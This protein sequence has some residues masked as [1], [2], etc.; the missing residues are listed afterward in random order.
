MT[1][2][3]EADEGRSPAGRA[4]R[5]RRAPREPR[6]RSA[7]AGGEA[8]ATPNAT[9]AFIADD[10]QDRH[11]TPDIAPQSNDENEGK[12][13]ASPGRM[14]VDAARDAPIRAIGRLWGAGTRRHS[15]ALNRR[16]LAAKRTRSGSPKT[17]R[18]VATRESKLAWLVA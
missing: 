7:R 12:V 4:R 15:V 13:T 10:V 2:A 5:G 9:S 3:I 6:T 8:A 16:V 14:K 17:F 1:G 11:Q 18:L